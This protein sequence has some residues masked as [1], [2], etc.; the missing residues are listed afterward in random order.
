ML[1]FIKNSTALKPWGKR[2]PLSKAAAELRDNED[3]V[4][5]V[6]FAILA[7][8]MIALYFG[9]VEISLFIQA[10][11]TVSHAT[12]VAGDLATQISNIDADDL[13]DVF[14]ATLAT[15]SLK[16]ERVTDVRAEILSYR[17]APGGAIEQ[18]GQAT[19]GGGVSGAYDPSTIGPRL[20]TVGS[21]AVV[22]R[23]EYQYESI[24]Y[25][26][27]EPVTNMTET[28]VLKPRVSPDIPFSDDGTPGTFTCAANGS[29]GVDCS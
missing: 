6:E 15:M 21:G 19:L 25:K 3:G 10:D 17:V 4:A 13:E 2:N 16:P 22:A 23:M 1:K 26:F 5:A 7:P 28:F 11:K 29:M 20:L 24:T 8:I 18:I 27:V 14:E 12:N 9:L